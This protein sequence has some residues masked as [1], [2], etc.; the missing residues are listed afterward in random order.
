[1]SRVLVVANETVEADEL[2]AE[3]RRIDDEMT[4]EYV[5]VV[6]AH[7]VHEGHARLW[8]QEGAQEAAQ[9]RLDRTLEIL[10]SEGITATGH[11][12]DLRPVSAIQDALMDFDATLI[13]ISTHPEPRSRWLRAGLVETT[14]KRFGRPVV[15]VVATRTGVP[16]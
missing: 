6:P 12:G 8:T 7:P 16:H 15:H 3:L 1:M 13:V 10:A 11:V 4:S 9:Q 14:R 5:V 2:L